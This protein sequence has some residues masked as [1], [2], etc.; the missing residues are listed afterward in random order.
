MNGTDVQERMKKVGRRPPAGQFW[1]AFAQLLSKVAIFLPPFTLSSLLNAKNGFK[2]LPYTTN[3][4]VQETRLRL[5]VRKASFIVA[6][7]RL[8]ELGFVGSKWPLDIRRVH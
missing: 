3:R 4:E 8:G 7:S 5:K 1:R 6:E 2:G